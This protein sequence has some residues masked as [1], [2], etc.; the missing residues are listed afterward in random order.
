MTDLIERLKKYIDETLGIT[1]PHVMEKG[2][3]QTSYLDNSLI[4]L[5][6]FSASAW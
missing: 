5:S 4:I 1:N 2:S 3:K 6:T